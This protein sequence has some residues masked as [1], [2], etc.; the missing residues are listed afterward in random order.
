MFFDWI[1]KN[2]CNYDNEHP[3]FWMKA[4]KS[5]R[6]AETSKFRIQRVSSL[7]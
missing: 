2:S 1:R 7:F 6:R 5:F 4:Y 3:Q